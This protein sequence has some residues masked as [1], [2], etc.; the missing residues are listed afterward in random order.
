MEGVSGDAADFLLFSSSTTNKTTATESMKVGHVYELTI[1]WTSCPSFLKSRKSA[2]CPETPSVTLH[3]NGE[4]LGTSRGKRQDTTL[5]W[6]INI[7]LH[8]LACISRL[9]HSWAAFSLT[10]GS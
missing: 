6:I 3:S 4:L 5:V 7:L 8:S 2:A 10:Y 9:F 1:T